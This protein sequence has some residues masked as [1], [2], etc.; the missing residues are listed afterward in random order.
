MWYMVPGIDSSTAAN[1]VLSRP[2]RPP[3][4]IPVFRVVGAWD[5]LLGR[6][7]VRTT[8]ITAVARNEAFAG[9]SCRPALFARIIR[10]NTRKNMVPQTAGYT[11]HFLRL[12]T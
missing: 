3:S 7:V 5:P 9:I 12:V 11:Q 6:V 8:T 4:L 2:A 10:T 1:T